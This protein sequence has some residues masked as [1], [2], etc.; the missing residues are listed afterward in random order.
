MPPVVAAVGAGLLAAAG[1]GI[2][3]LG[4]TF[5]GMSAGLVVGA[6]TL[7]LGYAGQALSG[8]QK[9]AGYSLG[10]REATAR[11][12]SSSQSIEY[13]R[14]GYGRVRLG[15]TRTFWHSW[16]ASKEYLGTVLTLTGHPIRRGVALYLGD[17]YVPLD[18]DGNAKGRLAG[19]LKCVFGLGTDSGDADFHAALQADCPDK[20][21]ADHRQTGCG[22]VYI[23]A[24]WNAA[25]FPSGLPAL[26]V[27]V[28]LMPDVIDPREAGSPVYAG[29][30]DNPVLCWADYMRRP[31]NQGFFGSS[32]AQISEAE[33]IAAANACDEIVAR[34]ETTC[35]FTARADGD[36]V[37]PFAAEE[38]ATW[39][40]AA[41]LA[42]YPDVAG[43]SE[44]GTGTG[45]WGNGGVGS[46]VPVEA[47]Y[48]GQDHYV[49]A[50]EAEGRQGCWMP[51]ADVALR[52][53]TRLRVAAL[54]G[55]TLPGGLSAGTDYYYIPGAPGEGG[56]AVSLDD[57]R[58][59]IAVALS[60]DS[61]GP[62]QITVTGEPRY[63]MNG[64]FRTDAEPGDIIESMLAAMAGSAVR[65]GGAW[66]VQAGVWSAPD[67]SFG[68]GDLSGGITVQTRRSRRDLCNC[69]RGVYSSPE[70]LWQPT[71]YPARQVAAYI[72]EDADE[73][74]WRDIDLSQ[75]T[76]S[77]SMAQR[78]A[79]IALE[80]NRRQ[81]VTRWPL[82]L[83]G[84]RAQAMQTVELNNDLWGW[85]GKTFEA[86]AC[87]FV[88]RGD[89]DAAFGFDYTFTELDE[90]VF[91]WTPAADESAMRPAPATTLPS[92]FRVAKPSN[93]QVSS[94]NDALYL[95]K[96]G[97]VV[98]RLRVTW[99][100]PADAFVASG[101]EIVCQYKRSDEDVWQPSLSVPGD[102]AELYI[103][104][105]QDGAAYDLRIE[106]RN[107]AGVGSGWVERLG[108]VVIGKSALPSDLPYLVAIENGGVVVFRWPQIADADLQGCTLAYGPAQ[109][110]ATM[111]PLT[112]ATRGTQITTAAVPPG[113]W[114]F[115]IKARDTSGNLSANAAYAFLEVAGAADAVFSHEQAP[116]WLG[117]KTNFIKHWTGILI[118][119]ST[120]LANQH[121]NAELFEQFVPYPAALCLYQAPE[122]DLGADAGIRIYGDATAQPGRGVTSGAAAPLLQVD[123]R[124]AA[125]SYDGFEDWTVG[126]VTARYVKARISYQPAS[127]LGYVA[128]FRP[129]IDAPK[130]SE[131]ASVIVAPGGTDIAFANR[132]LNTPDIRVDAA[133][134]GSP[135]APRIGS[136]DADSASGFR[137]Y[138]F[139]LAGNDV[140]GTANW[141]AEGA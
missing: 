32:L 116:D 137:V 95:K 66:R 140:G 80:R 73:E 112:E 18:A 23:R 60:S 67:V 19:Y 68:P 86:G 55:G 77:P 129:V 34:V 121:S 44:G 75:W 96:D 115:G 85:A 92:P 100:A 79:R 119:D 1:P 130:R 5:V 120:K 106:A 134:A 43:S 61:I 39:N 9:S 104:D 22:K 64:T 33:L 82:N 113:D 38:T 141:R 127:G 93:L 88:Q 12:L 58:R 128:S 91:A 56:L 41:Y 118:P 70:D 15:G 37:Y 7:A 136:H 102:M 78:I 139:D 36:A 110:W 69:V 117:S 46:F 54:S 47:N 63:T 108:Y 45:W 29:F 40:D 81:I 4:T 84:L 57:A 27:V 105:V 138:V 101:G 50:G 97:T 114:Y 14:M 76:D 126:Q 87:A 89:T 49:S 107:R 124:E 28:D 52:L 90:S 99:G 111:T 94:G 26:S 16:G 65:A 133:P 135:L 103:W 42:L 6:S 24:K 132:F 98:S 83:T 3:I 125:G 25:R 31:A 10:Q 21:T 59:G 17:E 123:Y 48:R 30:T 109:D 35:R 62:C 53:G 122:E 72:E 13:R 131:A 8:G 20:W 11:T 71:D 2:T 74:I 51:G